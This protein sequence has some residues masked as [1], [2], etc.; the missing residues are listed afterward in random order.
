[1]KVSAGTC[2]ENG[3]GF[4]WQGYSTRV[5]EDECARLRRASFLGNERL[6]TLAGAR[7]FPIIATSAVVFACIV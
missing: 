7:N 6:A 2:V 5:S 1:M 4:N 3:P